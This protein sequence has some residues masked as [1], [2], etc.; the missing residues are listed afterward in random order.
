MSL[1]FL[2]FLS[3]LFIPVRSR[4][5]TAGPGVMD[6]SPPL[7][8][9]GTSVPA[10]RAPRTSVR[11]LCASANAT[12]T[13]SYKSSATCVRGQQKTPHP[14]GTRGCETFVVPPTFEPTR[15]RRENPLR[16]PAPQRARV[17]TDRCSAPLTVGLP[18]IPT[19]IY[20]RSGRCSRDHSARSPAPACTLPAR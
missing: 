11:R 1:S 10:N 7:P 4:Q 15:Q 3:F 19:A 17:T 20:S 5:S 6:S 16:T 18:A 8:R 14:P 9:I 13:C 2:S 12:L